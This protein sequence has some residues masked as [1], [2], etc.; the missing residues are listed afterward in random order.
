VVQSGDGGGD[1]GTSGNGGGIFGP[2]GGIGG[3]VIRGGGVD[4]DHCEP[5]GA[6]GRTTRGGVYV[7]NTGGIIIGSRIPGGIGTRTFPLVSR[8]FSRGM[9]VRVRG[10]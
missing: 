7:P 5:P 2:G 8:E 1:Y 4:G 6:R 3:V 10:R 9:G